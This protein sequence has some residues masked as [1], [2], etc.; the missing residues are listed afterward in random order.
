[1][2]RPA[3]PDE[4]IQKIVWDDVPLGFLYFQPD[5]VAYSKRLKGFGPRVDE[6]VD[7]RG[8]RVE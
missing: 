1:M 5:I 8:A 4:R 6:Y 2:R 3:R 7:V